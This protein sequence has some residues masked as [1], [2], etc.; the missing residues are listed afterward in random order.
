MAFTVSTTPGMLA[1][2][3]EWMISTIYP[4]LRD[5]FGQTVIGSMGRM[6]DEVASRADQ[7]AQVRF[8]EFC[9]EDALPYHG[10]ERNL[11]RGLNEPADGYRSWL[12]QVWDHWTDAGTPN[13]IKHQLAHFLQIDPATVKVTGI[14]PFQSGP[15]VTR[16]VPPPAGY[17]TTP[18]PGWELHDKDTAQ[19][20]R[21]WIEIST[22]PPWGFGMR[23]WND[24]W[25]WDG[26][27]V[28]D[29]LATPDQVNQTLLAVNKW[30]PAH[31]LLA[32]LKFKVP[33][34]YVGAPGIYIGMPGLVIGGPTVNSETAEWTYHS[35]T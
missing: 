26:D 16:V 6:A 18:I 33:G 19:W 15:G 22:P 21:F 24:G 17:S 27:M 8:V 7:A 12:L 23:A 10:A 5:A 4:P 30:K 3:R 9:P 34:A 2:L 13:S 25:T 20:A 35:T 28:W 1:T 14:W 31:T 11:E 29:S 32:G